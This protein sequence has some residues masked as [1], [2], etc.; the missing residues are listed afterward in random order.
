MKKSKKNMLAILALPS[1]LIVPSLVAISCGDQTKKPNTP[2]K[3]KENNKVEKLSDE[4]FQKIVDQSNGTNTFD[5]QYGGMLGSRKSSDIL[6][7]EFE[8]NV[9]NINLIPKSQYKSKIETKLLNAVID[10]DDASENTQHSNKTGSFKINV[11]F[12]NRST[13]KIVNKLIKVDGFKHNQFGADENGRI[14]SDPS[15]GLKTDL[16]EYIKATLQQRFK[17]D[18]EKYM[19][20]LKSRYQNKPYT[21]VRPDLH[22]SDE[23][24]AK[25]NKLAKKLGFDTYEDAALKGFTLPSWEGSDKGLA[26]NGGDEVAKGPSWV[27]SLGRN[28]FKIYG[29][30]RTLP[31]ETYR[32]IALQ[33]YSVTFSNPDGRG[34]RSYTNTSG[35]AWLMDYKKEAGESYPTKWYL[36]T[37]V[38]VAEAL[39]ENITHAFSML[40]L[41]QNGQIKSTFKLADLDDHFIRFGFEGT[42]GIKTVY[43]GKDFLKK[44]PSDYLVKSQKDKYKDVKEMADFAVMELDFKELVKTAYARSG[45]GTISDLPKTAE[46]LAKR[47]T[48]NYYNNHSQHVKFKKVSYLKNY[49]QINYPLVKSKE[50]NVN[51]T[52][53][54]YALGYPSAIGDFFF[55]KYIDDDQLKVARWNF[56]LWVN[57]KYNYYGRL[58]QGEGSASQF[59]E[60][61]LKQGNYLSYELGYRSFSNMPGVTDAFLAAAHLGSDFYTS[62]DGKKYMNFG[63]QYMPRHYAPAGGASG[64]SIRNQNNELVSVY[65]AANDAAKTGLSAAFRSEGYNYEG[66][67]GEYNL[68][69]YDLIYGGGKDQ[70]TSYREAMQKLYPGEKTG[71]FPE[72]FDKIPEGFEFTN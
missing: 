37:N 59:S 70:L 7:T 34:E 9:S 13:G 47:F 12:K 41:R 54:L 55:E 4:E 36:G 58:T 27:D 5:F 29:L 28:P 63:L 32:N 71:L 8:K 62:S 50:T 14:P 66:A 52:D 18:N 17:Y 45:G 23:E 51:P 35:T 56:S 22:I 6:P 57:S 1:T 43:T 42:K 61:E 67:F 31:N 44:D 65:H 72:G 40:R 20:I 19:A 10:Q 30:A 21:E 26:I 15:Q 24:K 16:E 25:F 3:D 69:Q 33:T 38:H 11:E 53:Q 64:S 46:E 39:K 60:E 49:S 2:D 48:S 68:P